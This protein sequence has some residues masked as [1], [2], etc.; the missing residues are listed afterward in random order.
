MNAP[1]WWPRWRFASRLARREVRR[2]PGRT[3]LVTLLVALPVMGMVTADVLYR[4]RNDPLGFEHVE[5]YGQSDVAF[6]YLN[7]N[8]NSEAV[9][10]ALPDEA[11]AVEYS[12]MYA[13]IHDSDG[14]LQRVEFS[15]I[16]LDDLLTDGIV[17]I[18]RG[19]APRS[20]DEVLLSPDLADELAVTV[21]DEL[22][23]DRPDATY[24]VV[25]IGR[26]RR[27][28]ES[29]I[30]VVGDFPFERLQHNGHYRTLLIDGPVDELVAIPEL[31][32]MAGGDGFANGFSTRGGNPLWTDPTEDDASTI[33]WGW[34]IGALSLAAVGIVIAAAFATSARRQLLTL[35]QLSANGAEPALLSR[36]M[37]LQG[38]WSGLAGSIVGTLGALTVLWLGRGWFEAIANRSFSS[39]DVRPLD[40]AVI[41]AT[42]T[43]AAA[44]AAWV[45]ARSVARVPVL[46]ALAGR[47]PLGSVPRLLV[48]IGLASFTGGTLL[49]LLVTLAGRSEPAGDLLAAVAIL[50]GLGIL[51]GASFA[52][53]AIVSALG[54][55]GARTRGTTKLAA[56]GL[57]RNRMR[58]AAV[59]TAIAVV[60]AIT[61]VASTAL[62]SDDPD[63][64]ATPTEPPYLPD[65][66]VLATN[67]GSSSETLL[68]DED[69]LL[70]EFEPILG[71]DTEFHRLQYAFTPPAGEFGFLPTQ[72]LIVDDALADVLGMSADESARL[73]EAGVMADPNGWLGVGDRIYD[74][75]LKQVLELAQVQIEL[76]DEL[77]RFS[78]AKIPDDLPRA[79]SFLM[80][81]KELADAAELTTG[82]NGL[83]AITDEALTSDQRGALDDVARNLEQDDP[84]DLFA[85]DTPPPID[86]IDGTFLGQR[87]F[88]I[89]FERPPAT[90]ISDAQIQALLVGIAMVL[91]LGVI[92]VA[93]ALAAAEGREERDVLVAVGAKP[94]SMRRLAGARAWWMSVLG[95]ALAVPV[96][97]VPTWVVIANQQNHDPIRFPWLAAGLLVLAVPLVA[98]VVAWTGSAIAQRIRPT[99]MSTLAVD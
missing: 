18:R 8:Q 85:L 50:G 22:M 39:W 32:R 65:N 71:S 75:N 1:K 98:A 58:T 29:A 17:D 56:R 91:M 41:I 59:V 13:A 42:G 93:L 79:F 2:R 30:M 57:A 61:V 68:F 23:L 88:D 95:G 40:L 31:R 19:R 24:R 3:L 69:L 48:P 66:M 26:L 53:P 33:A 44:A 55:L 37:T 76:P 21:D 10:E 81:T 67:Y 80:V 46:S 36:T 15:D 86:P 51:A 52:S 27:A 14:R 60:G 73:K 74:M 28:H 72:L 47:R 11:R 49:L 82:T 9:V 83:L 89:S 62:A 12:T 43:L 70:A 64:F 99:T 20:A 84:F 34:V 35:G 7:G 97:F 87:F 38:A 45:P 16:P 63:E 6:A 96:G 78:I 54:P 25:G 94:A 92:T 4:T 90:E 77:T 5:R